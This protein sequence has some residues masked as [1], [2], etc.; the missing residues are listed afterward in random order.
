METYTVQIVKHVNYITYAEAN[1]QE[2][3]EQLVA[4]NTSDYALIMMEGP[5]PTEI[6]CEDGDYIEGESLCHT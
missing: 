5:Q 3:A 4:G 6:C 1:S 2:E